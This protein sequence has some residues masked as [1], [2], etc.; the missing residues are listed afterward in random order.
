M[1]TS[2][3]LAGARALL[4]VVGC[5]VVSVGLLGARGEEV[6]TQIPIGAL[7]VVMSRQQQ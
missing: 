3:G 2:A 4:S 5:R 7:S 1:S 6:L